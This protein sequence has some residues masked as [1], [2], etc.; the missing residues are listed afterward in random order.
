MS[1]LEIVETTKG[2]GVIIKSYDKAVQ[3]VNQY[4]DLQTVKELKNEIYESMLRQK[5]ELEFFNEAISKLM[6]KTDRFKS[7]NPFAPFEI[8]IHNNTPYINRTIGDLNFWH[9]T[10]ATI[11]AIKRNNELMI[12][13]G[14]YATFEEEDILYFVGDEN[15]LQRVSN[16][17]YPTE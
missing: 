17:I 4:Q 3:F 15:S 11:V 8:E 14:P 7:S 16:Y 2:S 12:S 6:E 10:G 1:D 9:N 13:P 5:K